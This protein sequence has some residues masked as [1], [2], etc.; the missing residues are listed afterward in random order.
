MK[1]RTYLRRLKTVA[2]FTPLR[3]YS[4]RVMVTVYFVVLSIFVIQ[5][6]ILWALFSVRLT[7]S[8]VVNK[9]GVMMTHTGKI[10]VD[11]QLVYNGAMLWEA[12]IMTSR[13]ISWCR[14]LWKWWIVSKLVL[15]RHKYPHLIHTYTD[16]IRITIYYLPDGPHKNNSLH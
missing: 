16:S 14:G 15:S 6:L 5:R 4:V 8:F 3:R 2:I 12:V 9:V 13:C 7:T 1:H 10:R 11:V